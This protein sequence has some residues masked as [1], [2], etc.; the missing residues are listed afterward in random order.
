MENGGIGMKKVYKIT[1]A[2]SLILLL[3]ICG[4]VDQ[5][6]IGFKAG[7]WLAGICSLTMIGSMKLIEAAERREQE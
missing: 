5:N 1:M 7:C 2:V 6:L 4:G 3:G